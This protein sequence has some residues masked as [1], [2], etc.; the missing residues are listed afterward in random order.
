MPATGVLARAATG[1][2]P[3]WAVVRPER[4]AHI[5]RV[6]GL[7]ARWADALALPPEERVRWLAAAW[8]HDA[9]RDAS[10]GALRPLV[11]ADA[12]ELP[13][14]LL[15]GPAAAARL[16]AEG[17]ADAGLL[18]AIAYHTVGHPDLDAAGR[19]LYLADFLDPGRSFAPAWRASL[20]ARLPAR[21]DAVLRQV[22][23]ARIRH[24]IESGTAVRPETMQFWNRLVEGG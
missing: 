10:P 16:R 12:A 23:G 9:L 14:K 3:E 4:E 11:P 6:A 20:R 5:A 24:L 22:L 2:L 17:V 13:G 1:V 8:L 19:A 15:H 7:V 18:R 21:M